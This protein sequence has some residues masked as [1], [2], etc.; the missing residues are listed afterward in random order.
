VKFTAKKPESFMDYPQQKNN[1]P[2]FNEKA[3]QEDPKKALRERID[4]VLPDTLMIVLALVMIP[5]VV[6]PLVVDLPASISQTFHLADYTIIAVFIIEYFLKMAVAPNIP[7]YVVNPWRLLDLLVIILPFFDLLQLFSGFGRWSPMLRLLRLTRIV[8]AGG[9]AID[10]KVAKHTS[11]VSPKSGPPAMKIRT[12]DRELGNIN[13]TISLEKVAG[14]LGNKTQTWIDISSVSESDLFDISRILGIPHMV[15]ENELVE[16][17]YPRIDYFESYS[18]IFARVADMGMNESGTGRVSVTR[19]GLLVICYGQNIITI[20]KTDSGLFSRVLEKAK[21]L[22]S[23]GETLAV[24]ILYTIL[25]YSLEKDSQVI[26]AIEH[27]LMVLENIPLKNRPSSFLESTFYLKKEVNQLVPSLLHMKEMAAMI[28]AK[29]VTLDG[30]QEKH[31]RLFDMLADEATY[32]KETAENARDNLLSL[33][34]LY[35]NT[36]SFELNKV[37]RLV[38]VITSLSIIPAVGGLLGSNIIGNPWNIELW[39][40]FGGI[41]VLMLAGLWIF[42]RLGW[43]KG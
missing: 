31:E 18:M 32:L 41:V 25:K 11:D 28:T 1:R 9:R 42:L 15:L 43:L 22:S 35:I 19:E 30:F 13:D 40:V 16:E 39:Q 10:R 21:K 12:I 2:A 17:S 5:I 38:A 23:Q 34:D 37:M 8:A 24:S 3:E 36:K 4:L 26:N 29:R 6:I 20:S 33:I 14:Y 27:E 7:R